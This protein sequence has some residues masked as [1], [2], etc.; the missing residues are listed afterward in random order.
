MYRLSLCFCSH[1]IIQ[2]SHI[3]IYSIEMRQQSVCFS[4]GFLHFICMCKIHKS[5]SCVKE[6]FALSI[7]VFK[8]QLH[9]WVQLAVSQARS[10]TTQNYVLTEELCSGFRAVKIA[11]HTKEGITLMQSSLLRFTVALNSAH[12]FGNC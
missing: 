7:M 11:W 6:G 3:F 10:N 1:R 9:H 4:R 5:V 2:K 8:C 12:C